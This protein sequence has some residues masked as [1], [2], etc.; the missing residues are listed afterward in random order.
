MSDF[1][2]VLLLH[3]SDVEILDVLKLKSM[4]FHSQ[5]TVN[6]VKAYEPVK[7]AIFIVVWWYSRTCNNI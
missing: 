7:S 2:V 5:T 3:F 6:I 4:C 1:W